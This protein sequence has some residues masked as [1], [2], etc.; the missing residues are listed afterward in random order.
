MKLCSRHFE[1]LRSALQ[2]KG[3]WYL[4][5]LEAQD[6]ALSTQLWLDGDTT[7]AGFDPFVAAVCEIRHKAL[8]IMGPE[9]TWRRNGSEP[10]P[11]CS[12]MKFLQNETAAE[13]WVDNVTDLMVLVAETNGIERKRVL[14]A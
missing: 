14:L 3:L 13:M 10:C 5:S 12:V 7:D 8:E 4:V 2:K 11:L 1:E 6:L 9:N